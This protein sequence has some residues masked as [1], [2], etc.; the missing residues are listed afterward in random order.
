M[1]RIKGNEHLAQGIA[2]CAIE[3]ATC[4][5]RRTS[6]CNKGSTYSGKACNSTFQMDKHQ[7]QHLL[8][9]QE[10][11]LKTKAKIDDLGKE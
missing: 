8:Q 7:W 5:H 4:K 2:R 10:Q 1:Q 9:R 6:T 3:K 11:R